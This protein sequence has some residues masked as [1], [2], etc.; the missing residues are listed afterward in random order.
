MVDIQPYVTKCRA[1][2]ERRYPNYHEL[3]KSERVLLACASLVDDWRAKEEGQNNHGEWVGVFLSSTKLDEGYSWCVAMLYFA[4]QVAGVETPGLSARNAAAVVMWIRWGR[5]NGLV[6]P[7][8]KRGSICLRKS[9]GM[10]HGAIAI[11]YKGSFLETIDGNTGSK[12]ESDGDVATRKLRDDHFW[13]YF[14]N[15]DKLR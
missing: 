6:I 13:D 10:S 9:R 7:K 11:G 8:P 2:L 5:D 14:L 1:L 3:P 4:C 12:S 15:L